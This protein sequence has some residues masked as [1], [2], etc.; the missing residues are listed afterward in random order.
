MDIFDV[1]K[2]VSKRK[3]E[4]VHLGMKENAAIIKAET[5]VSKEFNIALNDVR[6]L[7]TA[8]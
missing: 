7:Y 3:I 8:Y 4:L 2:A 6:R 1:L 5:Y